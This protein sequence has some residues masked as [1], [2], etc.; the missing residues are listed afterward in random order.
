M[1][2]IFIILCAV[3][4]LFSCSRKEDN[5]QEIKYT[6]EIKSKSV[7]MSGYEG[8]NSVKHNFR[9]I[10]PTELFNVIDN[11]SSGVFYL[12]RTNCGCCQRVCRYLNEVALELGVTVYY[13]DVYNEEEA[14][15]DPSIQEK[16]KEYLEP[17]L[18]E[19]NGEKTLLT[20]QVF[21]LINGEFGGSQICFD[22]YVLDPT[23]SEDQIEKFKDS[24]RAILSPFAE[25]D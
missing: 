23:P 12:G 21:S 15:T 1:K 7:D 9:L 3:L 20:P 25:S 24:Y 2:K 13:V 4:V 16:A 11:R 18:G 14:M 8:V 5:K 19:E 22:N 10:T 6:Y 17:I